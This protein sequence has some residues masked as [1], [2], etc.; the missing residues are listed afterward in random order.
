LYVNS[1]H[2]QTH[3]IFLVTQ[4]S[5]KLYVG[6][7]VRILHAGDF[8]SAPPMTPHAYQILSPDTEFVGI[9]APGS[10]IK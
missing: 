7:Q 9:I 1:L 5:I 6:D 4:G 10:W 3:D 2:R 8:G